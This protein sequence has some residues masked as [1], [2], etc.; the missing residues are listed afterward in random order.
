MPLELNDREWLPFKIGELF[1]TSKGIYLNKKNI[2][3]GNNPYITASAVNNGVTGFIGNS[4]LFSKNSITIEKIK[5][6]S[7]YQP[8]AYYC[9]HDVSTLV[10]ENLNKL[11][12][13]FI[14]SM[15]NRQGIKYSYGRQAQLNVVRRETIFLPVTEDGALDWPFMVQYAK[16]IIERKEI[17][18]EKYCRQILEKLECKEIDSLD[19]KEWE[20]FFL[21]DIF[22]EVK[23]GKRLTKANQIS[24]KKPYVSSTSL[25]NG[26]DNFIGND[27]RVRVFADCLTIANSG[28]V[29]A[30]FY[31]PYEFIASDHITHLKNNKF[32]AFIYH[33][34]GT[35]ISRLSEKYNFNREIN[36]FRISREKI[37]LPVTKE[38]Q[39][40]YAYMN[41]Y[42]V[43]IE[44]KKRKQYLDY[45]AFN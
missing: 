15:I 9:S 26:I 39:P 36:D 44:Y 33:F 14:S 42:M 38:G 37:L 11:S 27:D 18:Y 19:E 16:S 35:Q 21:K 34:I 20:E 5:L 40:D 24:G 17:K 29:G 12:A 45:L 31:H 25:N 2:T 7:F 32:N 41:Q 23:R 13:L 30:S 4:T 3:N 43:N 8:K 28:S 10:H 1:K 6:S 22:Q